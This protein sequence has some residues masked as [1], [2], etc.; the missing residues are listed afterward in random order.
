MYA[1]LRGNPEPKIFWEKDG[2]KLEANKNIV[3]S[4]KDE[5]VSLVIKKSDVDSS[6]IYTLR[7]ENT[8]GKCECDITVKIKGGFKLTI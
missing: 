1:S 3:M 8:A 7:A 6:G 4:K 5:T 2:V